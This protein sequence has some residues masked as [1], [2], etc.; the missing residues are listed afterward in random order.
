MMAR[1]L[2]DGQHRRLP[3]WR[4]F[5]T[6][7]FHLPAELEAELVEAGLAHIATLGIQGPGWMAPDVAESLDDSR[8][9]VLL[10]VAR[11]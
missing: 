5:T 8:L 1:E 3:G 7:F 10:T 6:S 9:E 11:W 2:A 4:V